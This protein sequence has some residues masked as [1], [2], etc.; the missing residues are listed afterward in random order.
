MDSLLLLFARIRIEPV[1]HYTVEIANAF[2]VNV[3][4]RRA[5]HLQAEVPAK[6]FHPEEG[7]IVIAWTETKGFFL[8]RGSDACLVRILEQSRKYLLFLSGGHDPEG[9][10]WWRRPEELQQCRTLVRGS[11]NF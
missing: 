7:S 6:F 8:S 5:G 9:E 11:L 1:V 2:L 4:G 10:C 3:C